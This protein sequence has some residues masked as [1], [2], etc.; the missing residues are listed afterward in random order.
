MRP[1]WV[2]LTLLGLPT[3]WSALF[4]VW[5][6]LLCVVAGVVYGFWF[7]RAFIGLLFIPAALMYYLAIR[8]VDQHGQW[9]GD[10]QEVDF[11][12]KDRGPVPGVL[13]S[14]AGPGHQAIQ[15]RDQIT[16]S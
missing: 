13:T 8:W 14:G 5:L 1:F 2:R 6:S 10:G 7:P 9:S 4:F 16:E 12:D 15:R 11:L 3:R